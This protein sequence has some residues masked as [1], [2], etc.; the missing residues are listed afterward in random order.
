MKSSDCRTTAADLITPG[1][2]PMIHLRAVPPE[3]R[4]TVPILDLR[5]QLA[6]IGPELEAA[7]LAVVRS[8][9]YIQGPAVAELEQKVAAYLGAKH[10]VGVSSGTDAILIAL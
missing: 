7:V 1:E 2:R 8:T 10:G 5:A 6:E 9:A 3:K 4:V